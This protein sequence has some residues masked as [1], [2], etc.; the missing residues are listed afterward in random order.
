MRP[1]HSRFA[2]ALATRIRAPGSAFPVGISVPES[3]AISMTSDVLILIPARM[4]STR[5]PG[6]PLADIGGVPMIVRVMQRAQDAAVGPVMVATDAPEIAAAVA[7][8]GGRAVMTRSDHATGSDRIFEALGKADPQGRA[9]IIVN[10]QGDF[11][12][13]TG[14]D[15]RLALGPLADPAVDIATLVLEI[16]DEAER[17]DPNAVKAICSPVS[18]GRFRALYFTR[19]TAPSGAG[20]LYHHIGLYAYR[21]AA[22]E[23]FVALP[24]SPLEQRERLEQLRALEADMRIDV[25]LTQNPIFGV[26]TAEHLEKARALLS[27]RN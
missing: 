25:A 19:A 14:D 5:L 1:T 13:L 11:P 8:A 22:L 16:T 6:K 2:A 9:K 20:P 23:C 12:M 27:A 10:V 18:P 26:D 24:P 15:I 7:A 4:A 3:P 17:T 21:R